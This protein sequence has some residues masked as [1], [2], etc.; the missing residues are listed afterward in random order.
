MIQ[1]SM[2]DAQF[3]AMTDELF[4]APGRDAGSRA[5]NAHLDRKYILTRLWNDADTQAGI[6]GTQWA[7]YQVIAE[8]IDH[9]APVRTRHDKDTARA[10]RLL[11]TAEPARIKARAWQLATA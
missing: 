4:P 7:G 10:A 2:T 9:H 1:A 8:Y 11:T 5:Q 3:H 6:R